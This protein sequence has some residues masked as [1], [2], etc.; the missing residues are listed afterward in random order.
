MTHEFNCCFETPEAKPNQRG[1]L[2]WFS[3]QQEARPVA[4]PWSMEQKMYPELAKFSHQDNRRQHHVPAGVMTR[5][6]SD[7]K[8]QVPVS[9]GTKTQR[10]GPEYWLLPATDKACLRLGLGSCVS[11]FKVWR[12]HPGPCNTKQVLH[13]WLDLCESCSLPNFKVIT[14]QNLTYL[15]LRG[16]REHYCL[17]KVILLFW[18]SF[19]YNS[20]W[21]QTQL[22]VALSCFVISIITIIILMKH[23][24]FI[25][26][27]FYLCICYVHYV[28]AWS[29]CRSEEVIRSSETGVKDGCEPPCKC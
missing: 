27:V 7:D 16:K 8:A 15:I 14:T 6:E 29:L 28:C 12:L 10:K 21:S 24:C 25:L 5:R 13:L 23:I 20:E 19:S 3:S 26:C 22:G 11:A 2:R 18:D 17:L 1:I 4:R 9:W